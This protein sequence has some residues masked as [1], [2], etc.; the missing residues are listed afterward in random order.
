MVLR[1][2]REGGNDLPGIDNIE[3]YS[4]HVIEFSL[5]GIRAIRKDAEKK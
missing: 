3:A 5:G 1:R 2:G 4:D